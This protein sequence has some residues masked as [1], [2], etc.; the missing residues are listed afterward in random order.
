MYPKICLYALSPAPPLTVGNILKALEGVK[1]WKEVAYWLG[2]YSSSSISS[3]LKGAVEEFL[4]GQGHFQPSWRAVIF[5]LDGAE[6][7][8]LVS[9]IRSYGEP[10]QGRYTYTHLHKNTY[11]HTIPRH[12]Y[13]HS[14][15][16]C[17]TIHI[18]Y[19]WTGKIFTCLP[20]SV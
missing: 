18:L 2:T 1:N 8:H 20:A 7:T 17:S 11:T 3:N 12:V 14:S 4:Q 5:A 16:G 10:V 9:R 15:V 13:Y 6:E 19:M